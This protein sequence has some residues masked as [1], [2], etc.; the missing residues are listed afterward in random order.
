MRPFLIAG[1]A[2]AAPRLKAPFELEILAFDFSSRNR[3][4]IPISC[5]LLVA[6]ENVQFG[7]L[8]LP[9]TDVAVLHHDMRSAAGHANCAPSASSPACLLWPWSGRCARGCP[10]LPVRGEISRAKARA[11]PLGRRVTQPRNGA[12]GREGFASP[13]AVDTIRLWT[14]T[15]RGSGEILQLHWEHVDLDR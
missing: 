14:L 11:L 12:T 7:D 2:L 15:G 9:A 13:G 4:P 1:H 5:P 10:S 6:N 3:K 8:Q